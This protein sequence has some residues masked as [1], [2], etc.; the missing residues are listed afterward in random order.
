M[1]VAIVMIRRCLVENGLG[2]A[3]NDVA[4]FLHGL[5][6]TLYLLSILFFYYYYYVFLIN[7]VPSSTKDKT[8]RALIAWI[9][10]TY[11]NFL[12]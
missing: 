9:V 2:D 7:I 11:S 8:R 10:T 5:S 3:V 6:F 4:M 12:A 1:V